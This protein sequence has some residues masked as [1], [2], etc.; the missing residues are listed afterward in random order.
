[1]KFDV[2]LSGPFQYSLWYPIL[3]TIFLFICLVF[4]ILSFMKKKPQNATKTIIKP[5]KVNADDIKRK[6]LIKLNELYNRSETITPRSG[7]QE[8][9][10]L[11]RSFV[12]EMTGIKVTKFTLQEID[13]KTFPVLYEII[14]ELYSPEFSMEASGDLKNAIE[15]VRTSIESWR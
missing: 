14:R 12:L 2:E 11:I 5:I 9:S 13:K 7:H 1:M 10:F 15:K 8:L 3:S 4:L 6:Y